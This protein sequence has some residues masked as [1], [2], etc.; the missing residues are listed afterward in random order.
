MPKLKEQLLGL[1]FERTDGGHIKVHHASEGLH[2]DLADAFS[3]LV[4]QLISDLASK[5]VVPVII[6]SH[7]YDRFNSLTDEDEGGGN[8]YYH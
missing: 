1:R 8:F 4:L 5:P 6:E 7:L 2:D 3:M